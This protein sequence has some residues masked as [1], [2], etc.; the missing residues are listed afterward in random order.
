MLSS[1]RD[2]NPGSGSRRA[3]L[4]TSVPSGGLE[5]PPRA[6]SATAVQE[7]KWA[8]CVRRGAGRG[9]GRVTVRDSRDS[10]LATGARAAKNLSPQVGH[11]ASSRVSLKKPSCHRRHV[12]V[13]L[14]QPSCLRGLEPHL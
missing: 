6:V 3:G 1:H 8:A 4:A 12:P 11:Q 2:S 7:A 14:Q 13:R 9:R 10:D 5:D